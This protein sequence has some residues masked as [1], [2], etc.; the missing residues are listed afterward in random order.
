MDY[1]LFSTFNNEFGLI[2]VTLIV[3]E[4]SRFSGVWLVLAL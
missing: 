1:D 2:V 3:S 4:K